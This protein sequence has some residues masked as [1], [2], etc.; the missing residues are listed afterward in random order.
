MLCFAVL[1]PWIT[2]CKNGKKKAKLLFCCSLCQNRIFGG[3]CRVLLVAFVGGKNVIFCHFV[4]W[5]AL[6]VGFIV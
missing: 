6:F 2:F 3:V 4:N 5:V 1:R